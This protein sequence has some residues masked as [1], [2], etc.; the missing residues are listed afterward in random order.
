MQVAYGFYMCFW[1]QGLS[2][3]TLATLGQFVWFDDSN[4]EL[5]LPLHSTDLQVAHNFRIVLT[6]IENMKRVC[7]N[8]A[9]NIKQ[10][11]ELTH[12]DFAKTNIR[13]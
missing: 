10:M 6:R 12:Q 9:N 2:S 3:P 7:N 13:L 4:A 11:Q 8:K 1:F 5:P